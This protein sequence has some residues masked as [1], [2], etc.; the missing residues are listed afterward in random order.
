[1]YVYLCKGSSEA[2]DFLGLGDKC[3]EYKLDRN[4]DSQITLAGAAKRVVS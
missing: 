4:N 1:M 3:V 2:N